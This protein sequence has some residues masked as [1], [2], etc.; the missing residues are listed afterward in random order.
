MAQFD[1]NGLIAQNGAVITPDD[2]TTLNF[3]GFWLENDST[4]KFTFMKRDKKDG[5]DV[6]MNLKAG[7]HPLR[8]KKVFASGSTITG[9]IVG[10][11][12]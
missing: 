10:L 7:Y 12:G 3:D 5:N 1:V 9:A 2:N 4:V 11:K 6:T 8:I